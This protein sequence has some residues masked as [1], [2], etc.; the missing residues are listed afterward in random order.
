MHKHTIE[1]NMRTYTN[2]SYK[3]ECI[4]IEKHGGSLNRDANWKLD[5]E[6][7]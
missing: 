5:E 3:S 6:S 1:E 7:K 2:A 4:N